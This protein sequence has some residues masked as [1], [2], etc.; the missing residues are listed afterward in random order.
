M[1]PASPLHRANGMPRS[2]PGGGWPAE[3]SRRRVAVLTTRD[4]AD[5]AFWS[6]TPYYAA[7][8]LAR[9]F[10]EL[11]FLG[12]MPHWP[13]LA[14]EAVRRVNDVVFPKR[15]L[16]AHTDGLARLYGRIAR[17]R[18]GRLDPRP[19]FVFVPAGSVPLARL[20]TDLPIV[21]SSDATVRIMLDYYPQFTGLSD[22]A[23]RTA[24][25]LERQAIERADLLLYPTRWAADSAV[26]DYGADP[27]K[28]HVLPY[29]A[30]LTE[31]PE[32]PE[33]YAPADDV[34]RLL[35]VGVNWTVKGGAVAVATLAALR[36]RGIEAELTIVGCTPPAPIGMPG[37]VLVP[38]L[39]KNLPEHRQR[40]DAAYRRANFFILPTRNECFGIVLCEAAAYGL[41]A[42]ASRTGG[43]PEVVR[44][45]ETGYTLP[46]S[47]GGEAYAERI[48]AIWRDRAR[49][50]EMRAASREAF[51]ARLNWDAWGYEAAVAIERILA[52]CRGGP[53]EGAD[54]D[55]GAGGGAAGLRRGGGNGGKERQEDGRRPA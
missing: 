24:D 8:A 55:A 48:A 16:S 25:A 22:R 20:R 10:G 29:G 4:A 3:R 39:D 35:M 37:L 30:N 43:V 18:L 38:F 47:D 14:M 45:G 23:I 40:L 27:A 46:L 1:T 44:E 42:V 53:G 15:I 12:P 5:P 11:A 28:V 26:R 51:E 9:H 7:G 13:R 54:R 6:G 34:C 36:A 49:Y 17:Q 41:P 33:S 31:V 52:A 50:V 21:Y 19:D 32:P 2:S